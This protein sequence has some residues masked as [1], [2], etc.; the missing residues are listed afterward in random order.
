MFFTIVSG[1]RPK[2][3]HEGL[4][5]FVI[6]IAE[7]NLGIWKKL[8]RGPVFRTYRRI[9]RL[10]EKLRKRRWLA[11]QNSVN[12]VAIDLV[13]SGS[14]RFPF[15]RV[16][17]GGQCEIQRLCNIWIEPSAAY[18]Q[19]TIGKRS[20]VGQGTIL[21]V[22]DQLSIG[23]NTLIGAYCYL[24][25]NQHNIASRDTPIRDQGYLRGPLKIGDDVWIGAHSVLMPNVTVGS[26]AVIGA[27]AIINRD[28]PEFEIWAGVPARKIGERNNV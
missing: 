26:G 11:V 27:G 25:T 13:L 1:C 21:S 14:D 4:T 7:G 20:F 12:S 6:K 3:I 24:L 10:R 15:D 16:T 9:G 22:S 8:N 17:L 19:L 23:G 28:I 5:D 2:S 18:A